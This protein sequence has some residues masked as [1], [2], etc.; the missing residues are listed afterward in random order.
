MWHSDLR[1]KANEK[2]SIDGTNWRALKQVSVPVSQYEQPER[3]LEPVYL[4]SPQSEHDDEQSVDAFPAGQ[5]RKVVAPVPGTYRPAG[6]QEQ[7][8]A[9]VPGW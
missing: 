9:P 8:A 5:V 7:L 1:E 2:V 6:A 4:P 3:P